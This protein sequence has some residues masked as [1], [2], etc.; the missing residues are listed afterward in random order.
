ME[1]SRKAF[2]EQFSRTKFDDIPSNWYISATAFYNL[3]ATLLYHWVN[4]HKI[5]DGQKGADE[6]LHDTWTYIE[7][8]AFAYGKENENGIEES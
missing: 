3:T 1:V 8:H 6:I 4:G 5:K 7:G 2:D